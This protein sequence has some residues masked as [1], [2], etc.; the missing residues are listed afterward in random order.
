MPRAGRNSLYDALILLI[1]R[2]NEIYVFD[3][4]AHGVHL[5]QRVMF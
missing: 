1:Q 3:L 2:L 4:T 5:T